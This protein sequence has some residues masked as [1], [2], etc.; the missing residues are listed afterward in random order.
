[1]KKSMIALPIVVF[2]VL[3]LVVTFYVVLKI[4]VIK[5][6]VH[7]V[8]SVFGGSDS[9]TYIRIDS[10]LM[11]AVLLDTSCSEEVLGN[12]KSFIYNLLKR[13]EVLSAHKGSMEECMRKKIDAFNNGDGYYKIV[14]LKIKKGNQ[15]IFSYNGKGKSLKDENY[16]IDV[17]TPEEVLISVEVQ[18]G[19]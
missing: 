6:K 12:N 8:F 7:A 2:V 3:V 15:D 9:K 11:D 16:H 10:F 18:Y 17:Y 1:M 19:T 14:L 5:N 13:P 4:I